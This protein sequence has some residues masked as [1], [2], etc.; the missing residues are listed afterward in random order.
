MVGRQGSSLKS[1]GNMIQPAEIR[2][3]LYRETGALAEMVQLEEETQEALIQG[4]AQGLEALNQRKNQLMEAMSGLELQRTG[5]LP[6]NLTLKEYISRSSPDEAD[7]LEGLRQRLL[8]LFDSLH[9]LQDINRHLLQHNLKFIEYAMN[10]LFPGSQEAHLY[11]SSGEI[12][13]TNVFSARLL[14][15]NA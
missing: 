4:D 11:A 7:E 2:E 5:A 14:D 8:Q 1:R 12:D 13:K 3:V 15:S 9:R 6:A 10:A